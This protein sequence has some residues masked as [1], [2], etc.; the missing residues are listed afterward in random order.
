MQSL[1]RTTVA[2]THSRLTTLDAA[3]TECGTSD[4]VTAL[5]N[6]ASAVIASYCG[7][8]FGRQTITET[9]R[10]SHVYWRD[11]LLTTRIRDTR[12]LLLRY[13]YDQTPSSVVVDGGATLVA[14]T[15]YEI[16]TDAGMMWRLFSGV[17]Q[18][19]QC[20]TSIVVAYQTGW[21]LPEE[22]SP[23]LP[24]D[25]EAACLALVRASFNFIASDPSVS[26]DRTEG[27]GELRYFARSAS[28]LVIDAGIAP[29][30]SGYV[31]RE[32]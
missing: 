14:D 28:A 6:R 7:R 20:G 13:A 24:A 23:T 19:W 25:I 1:V 15:D 17:R 18:R 31:V 4:D 32:W 2:P 21:V 10:R 26:L 30:L 12:P 8:A 22:P 11:P 16:D 5:I 29:M 9:F 27:V 3:Q